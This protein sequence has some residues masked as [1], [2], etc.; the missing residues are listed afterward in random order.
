MVSSYEGVKPDSVE[1]NKWSTNDTLTNHKVLERA[2][3]VVDWQKLTEGQ[4]G[5][6]RYFTALW[7]S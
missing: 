4:R 2:Y 6:R 1:G 7:T 5:A 3:E